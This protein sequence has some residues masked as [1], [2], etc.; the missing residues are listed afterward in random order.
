MS[1]FTGLVSP[2]LRSS[3]DCCVTAESAGDGTFRPGEPNRGLVVWLSGLLKDIFAI[4]NGLFSPAAES[5]VFE[6]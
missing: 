2:R 3:V 6:V 5:M 4:D 1:T